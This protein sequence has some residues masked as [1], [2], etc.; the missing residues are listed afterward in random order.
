MKLHWINCLVL[1]DDLYSMIEN[2][3]KRQKALT[4]LWPGVCNVIIDALYAHFNAVEGSYDKEF[5]E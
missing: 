2:E 1:P 5:K 4:G 3:C